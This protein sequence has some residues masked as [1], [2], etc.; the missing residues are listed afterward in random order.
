MSGVVDT[1]EPIDENANYLA[2]WIQN[3]P[4]LQ[5]YETMAHQYEAELD[6][7][8]KLILGFERD[9]AQLQS[10]NNALST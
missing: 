10:E 1:N 2:K 3:S 7:R 5:S 6:K 4:L 8:D 9:Q